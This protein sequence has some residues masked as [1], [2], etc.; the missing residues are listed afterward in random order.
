MRKTALAGWLAVLWLAST[1]PVRA[2]DTQDTRL[3]ADP[4]VSAD[5]IVFVYAYDL[6]V[7]NL[8]GSGVRRLTSHPGR[9]LS[10]RIS[11]DGKTVAFTGEYDGNFDVYTI[12]LEG[13]TPTRLTWHPSDDVV[14]DFT[15]DGREVLFSSWR[16]ATAPRAEQ[17]FTVPVTG[18]LP[19]QL[20]LPAAY[21]GSYSSDGSKLAYNPL[22]PAFRVWKNYRGGT[23]S[24]IW[25]ASLSDLKV[26]Q[27]P[28]PAGRSNDIDPMW[29]AG[30]LYF[31]S[32]RD[33][34]FNLY[35][36]D[37]ATRT[38]TALTH[39]T[40]FPILA[41]SAGGGRIIF[42]Q[43]GYLH[44]FDPAKGTSRRLQIG[45]AADLVEARPR[46]VGDGD[47]LDSMD[48]SPS[49]ARAVL[50][51][52]EEILTV[53]AEKGD[54]RNLTRTPG[55]AERAAAWSPDGKSIAYFSDASGEYQLVLASQDGKGTP[56]AYPLHGAGFYEKP[57]F[58]PDSRRVAYQDN[59]RT[60][61]WLDLATGKETKVF[62][63][64]YYSPLD[65]LTYG[66]S[67]DSRWITY[68]ALSEAGF[69]QVWIYS[70]ADG[71]SRAVTDGLAD[72]SDPVF[73]PSGKY[74][75][76][77]ASTDAGPLR[78]WFDQSNADARMTNTLY[79]AVL[80]K[81]ELSPLAAESDEEK[82]GGEAPD[83]EKPSAAD[84]GGGTA[85]AKPKGKAAKPEAEKP[86]GDKPEVVIDFEGLTE[87][88]VAAQV[89][90]GY[91]FGLQAATTGELYM[92]ESGEALQ[93]FNGGGNAK[94]VVYRLKDRK[95]Q[96][97]G[98][99]L[100]EFR[101]SADG[102]KLLLRTK[103]GLNI[104]DAG[105]KLDLSAGKLATDQI[106]IQI[107]P[108]AEWRQMFVEAWR[109]NRDYFYDPGMHGADWPAMRKKYEVFLP[110]LATRMDLNRVITWML[111]E[112]SVGHHRVGGGERLYK[113][114]G[115][116]TGLLG[117]DFEL[118]SGRYRFA[119]VFGGL[120]WNPDLRSPLTEPGVE[121][122]AGEYLL[123]VE[124]V[125]LSA[126]DNV[127][128]RF[129]QTAG[130]IVEI[131]VGGSPDGK[132]SRTVKVVPIDDETALRNR[133]WVE[134]NL[135]RVEEA[136][137]GRVAYVYVPDTANDGYAYFKRYFFPQADREAVIVDERGNG[138]GQIADYY[139]DILRR[140]YIAHWATRYGED[141]RT[142]AV[143]IEGP[144][145]MLI[146]ENAGSGGDLLPWMFRKFGLGKLIGRPT[147]GGLVGILGFPNLMDGGFVSAP[148]L[149]IWTEDGF[150]VENVGVAPDIEVEMLPSETTQGRD[151]QLEKAIETV[152]AELAA[153]P[154]KK[155]VRPPFP[156]RVRRPA[157]P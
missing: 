42:E 152:M 38:V 18:G 89:E 40:D 146:D 94:L 1:A 54:A 104:A 111:S 27:V 71:Q 55:V 142:P 76:F 139:I 67:P 49:G 73:D 85:R 3:L 128:Q 43:A 35:R 112:V 60:V 65:T 106:R 75:W 33:G 92:L 95:E 15:P 136:T 66:W 25:V 72:A 59:S 133:D 32:D 129:D 56:K 124:G 131:T 102:K 150:V 7:A 2:V 80:K 74:L 90:P 21:A 134:G 127:Y 103:G 148:N 58:S 20:P 147:W 37:P 9:E 153:H 26:E 68:T 118:D 30:A 17:L 23:A 19:H 61:W 22:S 157:A 120:N 151:P 16:N 57:H 51:W 137:H 34:E 114:E 63:E 82:S 13:G 138:G 11:P 39:F 156:I 28:Q 31:V 70:L 44:L 86:T 46:F 96:T 116:K 36:L 144:K 77:L 88:I 100:R 109:I 99:G 78:S 62:T 105:G 52:R 125:P 130:R 41:A 6:W 24:R 84:E 135:R 83:A 121:V 69:Q 98:E 53:P 47:Y 154:V 8:D 87:R 143:S 45:V 123:A 132:G 5:H 141:L 29:V 93:I 110:D 115:T 4:A 107:D 64:R 122:K 10:P 126:A 140:R 155:P 12:P 50:C 14:Q 149:G 48:L 101:L 113:A 91:H 97:L 145:V 81:G 119:K 108:R 79:L 117:A